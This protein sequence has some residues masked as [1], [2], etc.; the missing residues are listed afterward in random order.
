MATNNATGSAAQKAAGARSSSDVVDRRA[1]LALATAALAFSLTQI[2]STGTNIAFPSIEETFS[3]ASRTT[4]SWALSGYSIVLATF[5]VAGGR[6]GDLFGRRRIF[7]GGLAVFMGGSLICATAPH[8]LVFVAGR[9]VQGLG[10][11]LI[12]PASLALVLPLFPTSRRTSAV[13]AWA[14]TGSV[15]SAVAP[16][17]SALIVDAAGWRAVYLMGVPVALVI[18]FVGRRL[19]T[20][21]V[22]QTNKTRPDLVGMPIGTLAIGLLALAITQGPKWGWASVGTLGSLV[23][24]ALLFPLFVV[25]SLRHPE[26]LLN[27]RIFRA[28]TVWSAN[29]ANLV[30]SMMGLS[31]W[32]VWPL[33]M[34][35]IWKYS[36]LK[37]GMA[38]TPGPICSATTSL[39][40]G[41]IADRHGPRELIAVGSLLPIFTMVWLATR[42]GTTPQ[43]WTEIFPAVCAFGMGFGLTFSPLNGAA[44]AGIDGA[45]LGEVNA[46]FNTIRNLGGGLGVAVV[47]ALLGN[48]RP[49]PFESFN[50]VYVVM[51][52]LAAVPALV[53]AALYPRRQRT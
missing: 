45:A 24:A 48:A 29:L 10:G 13:A 49:I 18:F 6:L 36:L 51:A 38:I 8:A 22:R 40:A 44:L 43:Y 17:L 37:A 20:E 5:M 39:V 33:F 23:G 4:L 28:R 41:R 27:L 12:V 47:V 9:V 42:L 53:I 2:N 19:L 11:A 31:V 25:R 15:G 34:T 30:M 35:G 46:A 7:F 1:W 32:F 3:S 21:S 50:R 26:P 16:S 52:F 14:S